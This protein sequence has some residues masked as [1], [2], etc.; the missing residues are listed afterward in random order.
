MFRAYSHHAKESGFTLVELLIVITIIAILFVL[1][2]INLGQ[3]QTA[4]SLSSVTNTLLTDLKNQQ[5]LAMVG[6]EG[7]TSAQQPH[8]IYLQSSS[9]TLFAD[10][11]YSG[12]DT[13]NFTVSISPDTLTT[14]FPA[15]QVVFDTGDGAVN[16]FT[17]G[18]NTITVA[19]NGSSQT[20]TVNRFGAL[21]VH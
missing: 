14:T 11:A 12:S 17:S 18:N 3:A 9:Y 10:T 21:A 1:S 5:L 2:T 16:N 19:G 6:E 4:A 7:S 20:V 15:N 8:G 13:N